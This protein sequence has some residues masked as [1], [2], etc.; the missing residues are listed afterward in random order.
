MNSRIGRVK[1][2]FRAASLGN[3]ANIESEQL[4]RIEQI[5]RDKS[6]MGKLEH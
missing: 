1:N 4:K 5:R 6:M 3:V 2:H